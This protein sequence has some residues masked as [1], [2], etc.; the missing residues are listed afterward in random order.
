MEVAWVSSSSSCPFSSTLATCLPPRHQRAGAG[1]R[2]Q[3][4][5]PHTS[6]GGYL[7]D[8][9]RQA[10][11][12][13]VAEIATHCLD[14]KSPP[15]RWISQPSP[16]AR[17]SQR[18]GVIRAVAAELICAQVHMIRV[19]LQLSQ[20]RIAVAHRIHELKGML[21]QGQRAVLAGI[22]TSQCVQYGER[23]GG[24]DIYPNDRQE[25]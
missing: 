15:G 10:H 18:R 21:F 13:K 16:A 1:G 19:S 7:H 4:R 6:H 3:E 24:R 22:S 12:R 25:Y 14:G 20:S 9:R 8:F 11:A 2:K 23:G 17:V 5:A